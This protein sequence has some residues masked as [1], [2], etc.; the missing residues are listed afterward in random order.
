MFSSIKFGLTVINLLIVNVNKKLNKRFETYTNI[1]FFNVKFEF[2]N[3]HD[4][5]ILLQRN[6]SKKGNLK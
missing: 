3:S 1:Y 4:Q 2:F 6:F 5:G